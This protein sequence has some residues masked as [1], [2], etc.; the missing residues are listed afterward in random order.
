[1]RGGSRSGARSGP[2]RQTQTQTQTQTHTPRP[3][4]ALSRKR[5]AL[6]RA[7]VTSP[8]PPPPASPVFS[9]GGRTPGAA[10]GVGR[11]PLFPPHPR[12]REQ[13]ASEATDLGGWSRGLLLRHYIGRVSIGPRAGRRAAPR[14][15]RDW[16]ARDK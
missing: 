5:G 8:P 9:T 7:V 2:T 10:A 4:R 13:R 11:L 16:Q 15:P 3:Q 14:A 12:P 1:M 6:P